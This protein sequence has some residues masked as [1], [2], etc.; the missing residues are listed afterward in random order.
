MHRAAC[1][2]SDVDPETFFP[3]SDADTARITQAKRICADCPV[4]ADC[5]EYEL[6]RGLQ[7]IWGE[8]TD[9]ERAALRRSQAADGDPAKEIA[10]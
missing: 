1:T 6:Q 2:A 8:T 3:I 4:Q 7:G 9:A 5:R 10:A